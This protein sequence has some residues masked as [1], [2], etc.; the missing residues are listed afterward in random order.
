MLNQDMLRLGAHQSAIRKISEIGK[1]RAATYGKD[2]VFDFS[3]GDPH[4]PVPAD[5]KAALTAAISSPDREGVHGYTSEPGV[6]SVRRAIAQDVNRIYGTAAQAKHIYMTC[7]AAAGL[8][9]SLKTV[10]NA[11]DEV[12]LIAPYFPE[13]AIYTHSADATPK[14]VRCAQDFTLDIDAIG[15]AISQKTKAIVLNSPN[16]PT[17]AVYPAQQISAL[18]A[19]LSDA[20]RKLG[21]HIYVITD[22]PYRELTYD[23]KLPPSPFG[24]YDDT[25][26]CYSFSKSL[27]LPGERIGYIA[28]S[29]T[30][31]DGDDAYAAIDGAARALGYICAP[32]LFQRALESCLP[33]KTDLDFYAENRKLI[34]GALTALGFECAP[35]NGAFYLFIKSPEQSAVAF[36]TRAAEKGILLVP[37]D[38]FDCP[39]YARLA[40]C[41]DREIL[42]KSIPVFE[43]L[44]DLYFN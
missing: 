26:L 35:P 13:Y 8:A 24:V 15:A 20:S 17:G 18:A 44:R 16:N 29:P 10:C 25:I 3:I 41:V 39:G 1:R 6:E 27:S 30:I 43:K 42:A 31:S 14:P 21:H 4:A 32:S 23:G 33:V 28:I 40:Y 34:Y 5:V 2:S 38:E 36:C 12:I 7:G 9:I 11:G 22:E 37:G 19:L